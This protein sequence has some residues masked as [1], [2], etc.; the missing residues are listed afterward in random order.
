VSLHSV[1]LETD[2]EDR[3]QGHRGLDTPQIQ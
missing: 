3:V 2:H 1:T